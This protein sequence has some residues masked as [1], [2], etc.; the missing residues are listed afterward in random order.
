LS[1]LSVAFLFELNNPILTLQLHASS[2][3][4]VVFHSIIQSPSF[5][6][7]LFHFVMQWSVA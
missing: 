5:F 3:L 2:F 7:L 1:F 6:L 4:Q